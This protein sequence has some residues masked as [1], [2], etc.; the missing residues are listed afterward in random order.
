MHCMLTPHVAASV[1]YF[2][3]QPDA[4][5]LPARMPSPFVAG[6]PHPLAAAA[7]AQLRAEL[8]GGLADRLGLARDGKMFGVLVVEDENQRV[9]FLRAFSGM[10][11]GDWTV[12]GFAGPA[13]DRTARDAFWIAGEQDL[14]AL[15]TRI[16]YL[17]E[18]CVP[19]RAEVTALDAQ[20]EIDK[21]VLATQHR[22]SRERRHAIRATTTD[23]TI[24]A[25]LDRE[26]RTDT[27]VRKG[28]TVN[29]IY[30]YERS[31]L[32]TKLTGLEQLRDS[33]IVERA[34]KS[35]EL[36]VRIHETYELANARGEAAPLRTLFAPAE[37]PGGAGDCAAP[38]LLAQAYQAQLRPIALA[39]FWCGAP[40]PTGDRRDGAFYP[41]CRGKCGPILRHMLTGL[42]AEP[43]PTFGEDAIDAAAPW[44]IFEDA[45]IAVVVKPV[46]LLSVPGRSSRADSVQARLRVRY[47]DATGPLVPHRLDLDTSGL[48][49]V[50]KDHA[51]HGALQRQFSTRTI[52]KRY[53]AILDGD[54]RTDGGIVD[55]PL[56][57]DIDDR[58]RQ[59]VD[60][61][62]GKPAVTEW[63]VLTRNAGRT[64]VALF[65]KTGR[66]HQLRVHAAH[67][68]GIGCAIVG[69]RIYGRPAARLLLHAEAIAF[70]HPHTLERLSFEHLA[71]F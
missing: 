15:A 1:T 5:E 42:D 54:P 49:L 3:P 41:A 59:I 52:S 30:S 58:P 68:Q 43:P 28:L 24:L 64:R 69:D 17:E 11:N 12:A 32:V 67:P 2:D 66:A 25:E 21:A 36:L 44:T 71:P 6:T 63:R 57:G 60:P 55:L 27:L 31:L 23:P 46:G 16:A 51:S 29:G 13:F 70:D 47:P 18:G 50:A 9:G 37:P 4:G 61:V 19:V 33:V 40:P 26:S 8:D 38:K 39:E 10:V 20:H 56:R 22:E 65:P 34:A 45:W 14:I 7:A 35:R 53:I 62:H 48:M